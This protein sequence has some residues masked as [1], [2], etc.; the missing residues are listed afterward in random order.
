MKRLA[1]FA[2][3]AAMV[4]AVSYLVF[5]KTRPSYPV[6]RVIKNSEG[7]E[8][9]VLIQGKS[10]EILTIDRVSDGARYAIPMQSLSFKDRLF[11]MRLSEG[12]IPEGKPRDP[13]IVN[14]LDSIAELRRKVIVYKSEIQSRDPKDTL[15]TLRIDQIAAINREIK[16]LEMSI[17]TYKYQ[18]LKQ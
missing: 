1:I 17:E 7:K 4:C 15:Y 10:G 8:L 6:S 2:C 3:I 11:A 5:E 14:R 18:V 12:S 16:A 9:D 13:Y